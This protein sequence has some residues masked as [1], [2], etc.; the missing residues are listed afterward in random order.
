MATGAWLS[1][2]EAV[3]ALERLTRPL[4]SLAC[5]GA[6]QAC[7][8]RIDAVRAADSE[9]APACSGPPPCPTARRRGAIVAA[10]DPQSE[11]AL[12]EV[13]HLGQRIHGGPS[14]SCAVFWVLPSL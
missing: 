2:P 13:E 8:C 7:G 9:T 10:R 12:G 4:G 11:S 1:P 6:H 3:R 5:C 14:C